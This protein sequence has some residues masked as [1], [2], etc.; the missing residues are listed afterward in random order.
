MS[1]SGGHHE[2]EERERTAARVIS[3]GFLAIGF[4]LAFWF[5]PEHLSAPG[6]WANALASALIAIASM[7]VAL[8]IWP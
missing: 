8:M 4:G 7:A 6:A 1:E 3:L 5:W 2:D